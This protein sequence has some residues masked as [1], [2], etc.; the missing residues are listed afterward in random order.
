MHVRQPEAGGRRFA[1]AWQ[2]PH[3]TL[4]QFGTA[5]VCIGP[6]QKKQASK[7]LFGGLNW[8]VEYRQA[9]RPWLHHKGTES[10]KPNIQL[11]GKPASKYCL[12]DWLTI[13]EPT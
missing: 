11:R 8:W 12:D 1:P 9:R 4:R 10:F 3:V 5:N 7:G 6:C 2:H 13:T